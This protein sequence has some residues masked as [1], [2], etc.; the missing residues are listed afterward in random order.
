[1][2]KLY[3]TTGETYSTDDLLDKL[4][5]KDWMPTSQIIWFNNNSQKIRDNKISQILGS[6]V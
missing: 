1:M 6:Q 4:K 5:F 2:I 3:K